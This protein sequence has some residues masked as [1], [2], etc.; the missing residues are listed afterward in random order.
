MSEYYG[1]VRE[2]LA[3]Q[4]FAYLGGMSDLSG[5]V[6]KGLDHLSDDTRSRPWASRIILL[7]S[8][9]NGNLG[10]NPTL[11]AQTAAA[12]DV[13]LYTIS[14]GVDANRGLMKKLAETSHGQYFHASTAADFREIARSITVRLPILLTR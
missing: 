11:V 9:D 7:I 3:F 10:I 5:G 12:G 1:Q 6:N 14:I 2:F 13:S 8:D 4:E